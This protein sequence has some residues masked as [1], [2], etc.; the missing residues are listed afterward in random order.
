[1]AARTELHCIDAIDQ[2]LRRDGSQNLRDE[3][4]GIVLLLADRSFEGVPAACSRQFKSISNRLIDQSLIYNQ[5]I[6]RIIIFTLKS[7][8][9]SVQLDW[10][11]MAG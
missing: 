9:L 6:G 4:R 3:D 11:S 1:L 2:P 5:K 10:L 8:E 7:K